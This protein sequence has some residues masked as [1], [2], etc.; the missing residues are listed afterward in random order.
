[1]Y[2]YLRCTCKFFLDSA[3]ITDKTPGYLQYEKEGH[4]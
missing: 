3:K 1:M 2:G 4:R